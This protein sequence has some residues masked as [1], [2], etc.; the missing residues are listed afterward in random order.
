MGL[1][2]DL[3]L[4]CRAGFSERELII[5]ARKVSLPC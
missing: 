5:S 3:A 1:K 2:E 4:T